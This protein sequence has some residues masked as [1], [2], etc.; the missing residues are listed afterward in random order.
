MRVSGAIKLIIFGKITVF[1]CVAF[2]VIQL[3]GHI[4]EIGLKNIGQEF[5]NGTTNMEQAK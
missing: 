5:W 4:R 2:V 3:V 1:I